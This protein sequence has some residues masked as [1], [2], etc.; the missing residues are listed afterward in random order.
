MNETNDAFDKKAKAMFDES[1]DGLDAAT[2]SKLNRSRHQAL[3]QLQR[4]RQT[5]SRWMPATGVAAAVLVAV[6]LLQSP[7]AVNEIPGLTTPTDME[8]LLGEDSIEMLEEL[9]FYSWI[10]SA[11]LDNDVG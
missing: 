8:I 2:L 5:W 4:R 3:A 11:D 7:M 9:E 6:I 1:V 10:D